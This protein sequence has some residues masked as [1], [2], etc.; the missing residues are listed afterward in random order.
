M[1]MRLCTH[2]HG[3]CQH[4]ALKE[5]Q[6]VRTSWRHKLRPRISKKRAKTRYSKKIEGD[7]PALI[8]LTWIIPIRRHNIASHKNLSDACLETVF[9]KQEI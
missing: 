2:F 8:S 1:R 9:F 6:S 3:T 7:A 4:Q 5:M